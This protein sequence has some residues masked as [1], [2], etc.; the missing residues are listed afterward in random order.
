MKAGDVS[1]AA[2]AQ[3]LQAGL[4]T[5]DLAFRYGGDE[6]CV[7][8]PNTDAD[9][10]MVLAERLHKQVAL[11]ARDDVPAQSAS[12]GVAVWHRDDTADALLGRADVALYRAKAL[13]RDR[14]QMG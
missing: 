1:L 3:R 4:R 14:V 6:F 10:A 13:G 7:L 5:Q 9:G 11:P 12:L 2:F 8:L